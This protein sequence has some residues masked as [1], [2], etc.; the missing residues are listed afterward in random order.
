[1]KTPD[2]TGLPGEELIRQGLRDLLLGNDSME[3]LMVQIGASRM[4]EAGLEVPEFSP[5]SSA[6]E[7]SLYSLLSIKHGEEAYSQYNSLLRRLVSFER[8]LE[9]RQST[10]AA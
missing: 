4:R 9:C 5:R 1:M 2:L 8:A 7:L 3:A 6:A 10:L